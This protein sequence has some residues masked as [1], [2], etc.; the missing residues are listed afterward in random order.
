MGFKDRAILK[1]QGTQQ[2][3]GIIEEIVGRKKF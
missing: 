2:I 1:K 3:G